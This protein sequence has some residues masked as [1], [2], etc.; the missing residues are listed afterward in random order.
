MPSNSYPKKREVDK[1]VTA[2]REKE[3]IYE[4]PRYHNDRGSSRSIQATE[5]RVDDSSS[6][7]AEPQG[8][9]S[10]QLKAAKE[11]SKMKHSATATA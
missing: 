4:H 7:V 8:L 6:M 10:V 1:T 9:K 3:K 11:V 2:P 5:S